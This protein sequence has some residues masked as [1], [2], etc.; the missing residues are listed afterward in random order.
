MATTKKP[1][2]LKVRLLRMPKKHK[3]KIPVAVIRAAVKQ[4]AAEWRA[5]QAVAAAETR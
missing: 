2:K 3:G 4:V 5:Q 1:G